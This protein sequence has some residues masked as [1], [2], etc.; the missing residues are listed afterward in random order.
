MSLEFLPVLPPPVSYPLLFGLLLVAGMLGGET[1]R[2]VRL[3]RVIGFVAVGMAIAP[4]SAAMGFEPLLGELR[5]IVDI[6]LGLVL[7]DLGRRMDLEWMKRDWTLAATGLA[8][9]AATFGLVFA[10]LDALDVPALKAGLA[11]A[12][13]MASSPA[14]LLVAI[15]D[16]KAQGQ[17]TER[18][19]NLV[20]LNTLVASII[21]TILLAS[22]HYEVR[23]DLWNAVFHPMYLF[24]GSI[25]LGGAMAALARM[26]A[27]AV[28]RSP[29]AH[30]TL[31]AGLLLAAIGVSQVLKL[32]VVLALLT[33]GL[34]AR[35]DERRHDL[36]D[37]GLG[38]A[39]RLFYIVLFVITGAGLPVSA[40]E[41]AGWAAAAFVGARIAGKFVGVLLVAPLGGLRLRQSVAL[42][43]ALLPMSSVALLMQHDI[44]R[45][46]PE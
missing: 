12:I 20:A 40:F 26:L 9:S 28:E 18:A 19:L 16:D 42:A 25:A 32:P 2:Q 39:S 41:A 10:A 30:F 15:N 23:L 4:L 5:T 46:F 36:L 3:P 37:V 17:V 38:R 33:F 24:A 11:A 1:A 35:N 34:F 29:E 21:V 14:V 44:A 27:R 31:I 7:F 6:A 43:A 22:I 13:A 8:E 45:L